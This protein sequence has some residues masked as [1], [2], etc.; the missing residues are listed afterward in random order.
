MIKV[1]IIVPVY[2]VEKYLDRCIK[3]LVNQE[4]N[5]DEYEIILVDDGST[6]KSGKICDKFQKKYSN[7]KS[8]HI[9]NSGLSY[10][11]NYG[12]K[13]SKGKYISFVDSDDYV[14]STYISTLYNLIITYKVKISACA[15]SVQYENK[16]NKN[17]DKKNG[18]M[19]LLKEEMLENIFVKKDNIGLSAWG[20]M[21]KKT[22]FDE[23]N[24]PNGKIYEDLLTVPF[25]IDKCKYVAVSI[26][27]EYY[28]CVHENSITTSVYNK[29]DYKYFEYV[30][31]VRNFIKK[32]YSTILPAFESRCIMDSFIIINKIIRANNIS[33]K[34]RKDMLKKISKK[35]KKN[36]NKSL[37]NKYLTIQTKINIWLFKLNPS[38]Y[39]I[40]FILKER[41]KRI[42]N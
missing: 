31:K 4:F 7:I 27:K 36:W 39:S 28:Y 14:S 16:I 35:I 1:S 38:I 26:N 40:Y 10:A 37:G 12:I 23:I 22:L 17:N 30:D 11:R 33:K 25:L 29:N 5:R 8:F 6:D 15:S 2:N 41:I 9:K 32:R 42:I 13:F 21:Y 20:K 19:K 18:E 34:K 3:S 24:F